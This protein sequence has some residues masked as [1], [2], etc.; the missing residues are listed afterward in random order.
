M[1][2]EINSLERTLGLQHIDAFWSHSSAQYALTLLIMFVSKI[3][4]LPYY[5]MLCFP[6]Q[7]NYDEIDI[8]A[9]NG[10]SVPQINQHGLNFFFFYMYASKKYVDIYYI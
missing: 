9:I 1:A 7:I 6:R 5:E 8:M 3:A 10:E 4:Q 2:N